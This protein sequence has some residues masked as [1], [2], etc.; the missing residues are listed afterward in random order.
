MRTGIQKAGI[1]GSAHLNE[2][3][4]NKAILQLREEAPKPGL[5]SNIVLTMGEGRITS[6]EEFRSPK[7][8]M[9]AAQS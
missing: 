3:P 1:T 7:K 8:A 4:V 5:R 6:M 9:R 2:G